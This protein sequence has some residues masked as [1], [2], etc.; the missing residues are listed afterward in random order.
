MDERVYSD[1]G[2]EHWNEQQ[3]RGEINPGEL[4][5]GG[6]RNPIRVD[7]STKLH[8]GHGDAFLG[9]EKLIRETFLTRIFFGNTNPSHPLWEL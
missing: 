8:L 9:V 2:A 6:T 5:R 3:N 1:V 7:I 4:R